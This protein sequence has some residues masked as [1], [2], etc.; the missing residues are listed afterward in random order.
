MVMVDEWAADIADSDDRRAL[1]DEIVR[2]A[3]EAMSMMVFCLAFGVWRCWWMALE[4][5]KSSQLLETRHAESAT[6]WAK[7]G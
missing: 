3:V 7:L 4:E 6:Y 2:R 1:I 5:L